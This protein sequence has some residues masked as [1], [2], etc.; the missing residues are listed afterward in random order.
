MCLISTIALYSL[1][2]GVARAFEDLNVRKLLLTYL[3]GISQRLA[4]F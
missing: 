1:S 3:S 4:S 2:G